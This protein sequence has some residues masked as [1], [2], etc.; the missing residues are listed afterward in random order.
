MNYALITGG[1]RGIGRAIAE[2]L[3]RDGYTV[4]I[5]YKSNQQSAISCQQAIESAGGKAELLQFDVTDGTAIETALTAW[6]NAHPGE[7]ICVLVNNAGIRRDGLLVFTGE[8][9]W[10]DVINTTTNGFYYTTHHVLTGM[11]R[12]RQGRIVNITSV[13]GVSGLP[14]QVNYS[15]AKAALI[16]ATKA[17][18]KEVAAR[19][20]T[21]NAV[22]PGFICTDMTADLD[23][24]E[25]K[26]TIP[27]G[28]F[29][30]PEEVAA[31]VSFLC[32]EEAAYITGQVISIAGG[33]G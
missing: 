29:G 6:D 11:L 7:H 25:L 17:L 1:S 12:A 8:Q 21:V 31:L 32:S 5:N 23:E 33:M 13:S 15:A 30:K 24:Q 9:E 18:S 28:R 2:R 27:A 3:A 26:K 20:V 14:G 19:K 22:A 4:V 10:H 16:G